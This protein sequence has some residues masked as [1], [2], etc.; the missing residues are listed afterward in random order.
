MEFLYYRILRIINIQKIN[1]QY[2]HN[3]CKKQRGCFKYN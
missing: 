2:E 3:E 1:I